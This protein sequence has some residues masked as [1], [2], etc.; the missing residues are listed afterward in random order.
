MGHAS[1]ATRAV[2][3]DAVR[4]SSRMLIVNR[5]G[6]SGTIHGGRRRVDLAKVVLID[7]RLISFVRLCAA[8][9]RLVPAGIR[10]ACRQGD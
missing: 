4:V 9:Y 6:T 5:A 8:N 7:H 10:S 2:N 3:E 1:E